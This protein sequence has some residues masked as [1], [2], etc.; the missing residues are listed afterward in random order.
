MKKMRRLASLLLALAMA[1]GLTATAL[2]A[3]VVNKT[4]HTYAAYQVFSRLPSLARRT[5]NAF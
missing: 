1:F 5:A 3:D 4:G 2:A